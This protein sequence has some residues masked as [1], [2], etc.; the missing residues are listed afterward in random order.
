ME[1][2]EGDLEMERIE[3]RNKVGGA[4]MIWTGYV[5]AVKEHK[6]PQNVGQPRKI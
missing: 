2:D 3:E 5:T 6:V 4:K 1:E